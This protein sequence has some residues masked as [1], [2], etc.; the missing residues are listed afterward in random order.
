M[1]VAS[2]VIEDEPSIVNGNHK[3]QYGDQGAKIFDLVC[4]GFGPASLAIAVA[5]HDLSIPANV[6]FLERQPRFAWHAGM[7]LSGARMQ[8]SF[9]KDVRPI[10]FYA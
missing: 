8:I 7:L 3:N 5:L 1:P 6:L 10:A 9:L 2:S 4:I